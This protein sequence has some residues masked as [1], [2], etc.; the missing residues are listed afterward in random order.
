MVEK[1]NIPYYFYLIHTSSPTSYFDFK[2]RNQQLN[3]IKKEFF[4]EHENSRDEDAK[5]IMI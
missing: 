4:L 1:D 3:I 5:I 2:K